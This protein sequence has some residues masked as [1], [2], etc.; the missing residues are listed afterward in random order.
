MDMLSTH[1]H[2]AQ[3]ALGQNVEAKP[4][5]AFGCRRQHPESGR[6]IPVVC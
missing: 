5:G 3:S 6:E 2:L 1:R 4:V